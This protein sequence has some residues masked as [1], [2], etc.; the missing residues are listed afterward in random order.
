MGIASTCHVADSNAA[1]I[2]M[3]EALFNQPFDATA[4]E[5]RASFLNSKYNNE[6]GVNALMRMLY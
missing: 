5:A 6:K 4:H 2:Q 1:F 3:T